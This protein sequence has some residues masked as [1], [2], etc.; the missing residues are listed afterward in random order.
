MQDLDNGVVSAL[1]DVL[2]TQPLEVAPKLPTGALRRLW[3]L[4]LLLEGAASAAQAAMNVHGQHR[5]AYQQAFEGA[6]E[7]AGV[8]I[9]P[10]EYDVQIDWASGEVRFTPR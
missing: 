8:A 1:G 2:D 10:G 6:C 5:Q 7:D 3:R 4:G 9:P